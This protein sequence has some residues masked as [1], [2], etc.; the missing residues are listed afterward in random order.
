[1]DP[2][3]PDDGPKR[4]RHRPL[5]AVLVVVL[6]LVLGFV[7]L[8]LVL[9][10]RLAGHLGRV[11]GAFSALTD[12]PSRPTGRAGSAINILLLTV[13]RDQNSVT[14]SAVGAPAWLP[15]AR[16]VDS[17]LVL[18]LD[19]DRRAA[20]VTAIPLQS[21]VVHPDQVTAQ[22]GTAIGRGGPARTVATVEQLTG[23]RIDHLLTVDWA[24]LADLTDKAGDVQLVV[25][26]TVTDPDSGEVWQAGR[27]TVDGTRALAYLRQGRG[28]ADPVLGPTLRQQS[29]LREIM[30][31]TLHT[32]FRKH[33]FAL[34]GVLDTL[35]RNLSVDST[36]SAGSMRN[37][38]IS[39][40]NLRSAG[41]DYLVA[42]VAGST[43]AGITLDPVRSKGLW[44]ALRGDDVASWADRNPSVRVP[45]T[46]G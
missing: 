26:T 19:A 38:G 6:V 30:D 32:A 2:G 34:Y 5:R 33:P 23:V 35:S 41:I 25:P 15:R 12:R 3:S 42:P 4:R 18:H 24:G 20:S 11:D 39:L 8:A 21:L 45:P 29:M 9:Q 1:M 10:Q 43:S 14:P 31:E 28:L 37:L 22:L 44:E 40:R 17:L 36:W 46:V 7:G 16:H 13:D 27:S